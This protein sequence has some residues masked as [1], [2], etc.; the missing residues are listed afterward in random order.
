MS[1]SWLLVYLGDSEV[2]NSAFQIAEV[3]IGVQHTRKM[4]KLSCKSVLGFFELERFLTD[5]LDTGF[6]FREHMLQT[7]AAE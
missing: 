3:S 5:L 7:N 1:V 6:E 2:D 4:P